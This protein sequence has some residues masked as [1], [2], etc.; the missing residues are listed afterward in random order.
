M[1]G[2]AWEWLAALDDARLEAAHSHLA[3]DPRLKLLILEGK[4]SQDVD[5]LCAK[6]PACAVHVAPSGPLPR[7][8]A[9]DTVRNAWLQALVAF[10]EARIAEHVHGV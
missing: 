4:P 6:S 2:P 1:G 7:E 8:L 5:A 10:T 9:P 3:F